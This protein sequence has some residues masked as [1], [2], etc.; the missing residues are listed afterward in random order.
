MAR[1]PVSHLE[2]S[3]PTRDQSVMQK[4]KEKEMK[5]KTKKEGGR[6]EEEEEEEEE[7]KKKKNERVRSMEGNALFP[8]TQTESGFSR[9]IYTR[10]TRSTM[11][12]EGG[13]DT[14]SLVKTRS[15]KTHEECEESPQESLTSNS[16]SARL[17]GSLVKL[18]SRAVVLTLTSP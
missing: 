17:S 18:E 1:L 8:S 12:I 5:K 10:Q 11:E 9:R 16:L 7:R 3:E 13:K 14:L 6:E 2:P 15:A 4:K